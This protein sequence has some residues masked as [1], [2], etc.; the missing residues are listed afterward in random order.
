MRSLA[1]VAARTGATL[2]HY[3]TDFVFDGADR[4]TPYTEAD[5]P[6]PQSVYGTSK[7]V[8]EWLAATAPRA[9]VLR[10]ESLFGGVYVRSSV[11]KLVAGLERGEPLRVFADRTLTP[12]YVAD[13]VEATVPAGRDAARRP[14]S[15]TA[16]TAA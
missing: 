4:T 2:V 6:R 1:A 16:S 3:S 13:V 5:A 11:D 8:G 15:T 7:L 12:S 10:V 14:A 9:Y